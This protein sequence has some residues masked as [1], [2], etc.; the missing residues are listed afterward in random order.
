MEYKHSLKAKWQLTEL[1]SALVEKVTFC[2]ILYC[3][4]FRR[5]KYKMASKHEKNLSRLCRFCCRRETNLR[6]ISDKIKDIVFSKYSINIEC[7]Q[8][9]E[10]PD[11]MCKSCYNLILKINSGEKQ[12]E[13][14]TI[15]KFPAQ[16]RPKHNTR[17]AESVIEQEEC[18]ADCIV[19]H[20]ATRPNFGQQSQLIKKT[21][22]M[23]RPSESFLRKKVYMLQASFR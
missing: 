3:V 12:K 21:S 15:F 18:K 10:V 2:E 7:D 14:L 13:D 4:C 6:G 1:Y 20:E 5:E 22:T 19:C 9:F 8:H 17:A 11:R 23:G 16:Q